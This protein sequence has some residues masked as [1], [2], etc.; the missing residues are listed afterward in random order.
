MGS[1]AYVVL[2][3]RWEFLIWTLDVFWW[4]LGITM[5]I[6]YRMLGS[7]DGFE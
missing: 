3:L 5:V 4:G 7:E 2:V 6:G 1:Y